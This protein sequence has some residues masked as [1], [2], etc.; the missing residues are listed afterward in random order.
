MSSIGNGGQRSKPITFNGDLHQLPSALAPLRE[1]PNWVCWSWVWKEKECKWDKPPFQPSGKHAQNNNAATWSTYETVIN[2]VTKFDGIGF[3]LTTG[4]IVAFDID[5]CRNVE[6]GA[7]DDWAQ[8]L[9]ERVDSYTEITVSGT[10]LRIIGYGTGTKLHR[11]QSVANGVSL[12]TYRK[13]ERYITITGNPLP[14]F[15]KPLVN[16]DTH[17]D[18]VVAELDALKAQNNGPQS[19]TQRFKANGGDIAP[20]QDAPRAAAEIFEQLPAGLRKVVAAAPYQGEDTSET[21][22]SVFTQLVRL[23][24]TDE[25][26]EALFK[27]HPHGIGKRYVTDGKNLH[28]DIERM[29]TKFGEQQVHSADLPKR[30]WPTMSQDAYYGFAGK[31]V[32]TIQPHSEADPVALLTQ[33]LVCFG[34]VMGHHK[35]YRIE[36]ERHY[37]NLFLVLVGATAQRKG[38]ALNRVKAVIECVDPQWCS[39]CIKSGVSSGEGL[40][41]LVRDPVTKWNAKENKDEEVDPGVADKRLLTIEP[42]FASILANMDRK[43]STAS[44]N[45]RKAWDGWPLG[46]LTR[47]NPITATDAH[48]SVIAHITDDE[49]RSR[50]TRTD[51]ANGFANRLLFPLVK[52]SKLLPFGGDL[53][54]A[55]IA[56][57]GAE[58]RTILERNFAGPNE[59]LHSI[60]LTDAAREQWAHI[61]QALANDR[62]VGLIGAITGRA[63]A[64]AIRLALIYALLDCSIQIDVQ[65]IRAGLAVWEYC[66]ASA[67][68]IFGDSMGDEIADAILRALKACPTGMSRTEIS[69]LF[70]N[71]KRQDQISRA[72][73]LLLEKS[74]A[75]VET[76]TT[77]GRP[78]EL[79][80]AC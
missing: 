14:G 44:S 56:E 53:S 60:I 79:W 66:A 3:C 37:T 69:S 36:S 13:A 24:H 65:H 76:K 18:A 42:E 63:E 77:K 10:G 71:N 55:T 19:S 16:I 4:E 35:Y 47:K 51:M 46:T 11:K 2:A 22:A 34:N 73:M 28:A 67:A 49:L 15:D 75:R 17:I 21:A 39:E 31:V 7:L 50:L 27:A 54:D 70:S 74:R 23:N 45:L 43:E 48:I 9:V 33:L 61:Y 29:R 5:K 40:I 80:F 6:T 78:L 20:E 64:Q 26:I 57:L 72:L 59:R 38:V 32:E 68:Y 30:V 52:R 58:L 41:E 25:E 1:L 12:E 62:P 8:S